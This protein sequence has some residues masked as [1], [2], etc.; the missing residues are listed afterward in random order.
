MNPAGA[1]VSHVYRTRVAWVD[2]DASGLIHFTAAF[3]WAEAAEHD[4]LRSLGHESPGGFPRVDVQA[5]Y[6]APLHFGDELEVRIGVRGLGSTSITYWWD[7]QHRAA[8]AIE[9]HHT[10]VFVDDC[11]VPTPL[12]GELRTQLQELLPPA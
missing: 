10:V 3:R 2:T 4:L 1:A 9:G 5:S 11:G 8:L 7:I 12:P 6:R